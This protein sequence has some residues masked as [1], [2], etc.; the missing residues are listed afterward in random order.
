M[1]IKVA[2]VACLLGIALSTANAKE[3]FPESVFPKNSAVEIGD[4]LAGYPVYVDGPSWTYTGMRVTSATGGTVPVELPTVFRAKRVNG[5]LT[6]GAATTVNVGQGPSGGWT[7]DPCGGD[8]IFKINIVRSMLDRCAVMRFTEI[9][10]AGVKTTVLQAEA[11]ETS[12]DGRYYKHIIFAVMSNLGLSSNSFLK[13]TPFEP[14]AMVW[15]Q[16]F[17]NATIKAADFDKSASAFAAVPSFEELITSKPVSAKPETKADITPKL[18]SAKAPPSQQTPIINKNIT[19][20]NAIEKC[21]NLGFKAGT[22]KFG[23]CVM[24]LLK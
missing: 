7:G 20:D 8:T 10:I 1:K 24:T 6:F 11:I 23:D 16:E 14:K 12:R 2:V 21:S 3:L 15:L 13:G 9:P 4:T 18:E 17:L 19:I 5:V 22:E